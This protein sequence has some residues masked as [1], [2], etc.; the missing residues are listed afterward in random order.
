MTRA[1]DTLVV[2]TE[3]EG[4]SPFLD[5]IKRQMSLI[6]LDWAAFL[7]VASISGNRLVVQVKNQPGVPFEIGTFAVKNQLKACRYNWHAVN[8]VW[9]KGFPVDGF[10]FDIVRNEVWATA[11]CRVDISVVDDSGTELASYRLDLGVWTCR[12]DNLGIAKENSL[13]LPLEAV[14]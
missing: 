11:A 14:K 10:N 1:I 9:E 12:F 13:D 6:P 3:G 2:F 7:S 5:D 4:K 8:E